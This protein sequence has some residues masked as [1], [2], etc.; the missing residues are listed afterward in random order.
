MVFEE[1]RTPRVLRAWEPVKFPLPKAR[2]PGE[3][4]EGLRHAMERSIAVRMPQSGTVASMLSSG[5][6]SSSVTAI[7]AKLLAREGRP[8]IAYTSSPSHAGCTAVHSGRFADEW[9]LAAQVAAMYSNVKHIRTG[10][11][12]ANWWTAMDDLSDAWAGPPSFLRNFRWFYA[13]LV[14]AQRRGVSTMFEGS[15]GN[16]TGS[17]DGTFGLY[18]LLRRRRL[19]AFSRSVLELRRRGSGWKQLLL[20]TWLPSAHLYSRLKHFLRPGTATILR[21]VCLLNQQLY[22]GLGLDPRELSAPGGMADGDRRSGAH[23]R[24]HIL[25]RIDMG[26]TN[27]AYMRLFG[28]RRVDPTADRKLIEFCLSIPDEAFHPGGIPRQ[29]YR[30]A[31]RDLL[32][33]SLLQEKLRGL[34]SSD[35]LEMFEDWADE[36]KDEV[37]RIAV[38]PLASQMLDVERMRADIGRWPEAVKKNRVQADNYYNFTF[39]S[40]LGMGRFLRRYEERH[41]VCAI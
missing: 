35:F 9:P 28:I 23:W 7:A 29:L 15:T 26:M 11:A 40:A 37:E 18:D 38:S 39:G 36:F 21:D 5:L 32:P 25:Q 34:Q 2:D 10:T 30:D 6:D 12:D 33:C 1:P 8:L 41:E 27:A 3:Y 13:I 22:T 17:Y 19:A 31:M 14:D 24:F 20:R 4:A 16:L